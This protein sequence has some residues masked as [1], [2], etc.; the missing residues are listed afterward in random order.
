VTEHHQL[1]TA[2]CDDEYARRLPG[3]EQMKQQFLP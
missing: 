1:L 3:F 2:A